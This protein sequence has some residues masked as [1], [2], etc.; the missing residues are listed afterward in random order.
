MGTIRNDPPSLHTPGATSRGG[1]RGSSPGAWL[2]LAVGL[3]LTGLA[4]LLVYR[5][6]EAQERRDFEARSRVLARSLEQSFALPLESLRAISAFR[7]VRTA[8]TEED[9]ERFASA[10]RKDHPSLAALEWAELVE[11]ERRAS[12]EAA[13]TAR[14]GRPFAI[15]EPIDGQMRPSP[16][17]ARYAP[18]TLLHPFLLDIEGLDVLFEP[19]RRASID[20]ALQQRKTLATAKF[21]LVEDPPEVFSV[22]VYDPVFAGDGGPAF[23]LSIALFRIDPLVRHAL[24]STD[25]STLDFALVD[26]DAGVGERLLFVSRPGAEQPRGARFRFSR[27]MVFV[28][29]R[30]T[31]SFA[32]S[33]P[34]SSLAPWGVLAAGVL[35][36]ALASIFVA[37]RQARKHLEKALQAEREL[38]SYTLVKPLGEG[39]MGSVFEGAHRI[40]RR[41]VAIKL[42][43][44]GSVSPE[45][46]ERFAREARTLSELSHPN[47]VTLY[48]YGTAQ[49][50]RLYLV[51]EYLDGLTF[52][53]LLDHFRA[54]PP[55]R[56]VRLLTQICEALAEAH[57]KGVVHRDLKPANLMICRVGGMHDFVKILDFGLAKMSRQEDSKL[58]APGAV[59][60]TFS[61][62]APECLVDPECASPRSDIY[63]LG[64]VAYE[65]LA[66]H[67]V[68][69]AVADS[70]AQITAHLVQPPPPLDTQEIGP[71]LATIV[72]RCLEKDPGA[73]YQSTRQLAHALGRVPLPPWTEVDAAEWW[74]ENCAV[75]SVTRPDL[76]EPISFR[77]A[78][79]SRRKHTIRR[80][81]P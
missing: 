64:C 21:R 25:L 71:E 44:A 9:F 37:Q 15:R 75:T 69:D 6:E 80:P 49:D 33:A 20:A 72:L 22:A 66:G 50:G 30:W 67:P 55:A 76:P 43:R 27:G 68:F 48:D 14:L 41:R 26:E 59:L 35:L 60:G 79:L 39:G 34:A 13:L 77:P 70:T 58:S 56:V 24:G 81:L 54:Q 38:G 62:I 53:T 18:L 32:T 2:V 65:L 1:A 3:A 8:T 46:T 31:A 78:A 10:L 45:L 61:Y 63:A 19:I 11:D 17:R 4:A 28:G 16:R 57:D 42:I 7:Q 73:R 74:E 5:R 29:R 47:T 12:V 52:E 36:S 23:G 40:L 51:M